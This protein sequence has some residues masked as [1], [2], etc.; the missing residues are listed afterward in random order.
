[1]PL[2]R[3]IWKG[4]IF[5][6][7]FQIFSFT[8]DHSVWMQSGT[9]LNARELL[10]VYT[11]KRTT[12][13]YS[14]MCSIDPEGR[15]RSPSAAGW[16]SISIDHLKFETDSHTNGLELWICRPINCALSSVDYWWVA[17]GSS[18]SSSSPTSSAVAVDE[19]STLQHRGGWWWFRR[20]SKFD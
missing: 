1:M 16:S 5:L 19:R 11:S 6:C 14:S 20:K 15:R 13:V 12:I 17:P 9:A 7:P 18:A 3:F 2:I 10:L 4:N 8:H